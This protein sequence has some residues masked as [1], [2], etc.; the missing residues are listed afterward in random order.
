M[1]R[2]GAIETVQSAGYEALEAADADEAIRTLELRDDINLV[3]TDVQR[4]GTID[5]IK[6]SHY[7]RDWWPPVSLIV[8]SGN[9]IVE[10]SNLPLGSRFFSNLY[11]DGL[12]VDAMARLRASDEQSTIV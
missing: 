11:D 4:P 3:F 12:I 9:A 2:I 7:I 1:I 5:G 8:A 10:E 6:L